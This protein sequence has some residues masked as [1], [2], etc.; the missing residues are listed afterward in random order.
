MSTSEELSWIG[1]FRDRYKVITGV[2]LSTGTSLTT[3]NIAPLNL[4]INLEKYEP[5]V[6]LE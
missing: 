4:K 6:E 3:E 2:S 5:Y 1:N